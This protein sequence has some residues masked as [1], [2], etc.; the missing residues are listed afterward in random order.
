VLEAIAQR[1]LQT[2]TERYRTSRYAREL[3]EIVSKIGRNSA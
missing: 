1:N 2:A 3:L